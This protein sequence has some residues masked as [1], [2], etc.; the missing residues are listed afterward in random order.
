MPYTGYYQKGFIGSRCLFHKAINSA[1]IVDPSKVSFYFPT[2]AAVS[3]FS[4]FL[5]G[6]TLMVV[7]SPVYAGNNMTFP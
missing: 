6:N 7:N 3:F 1:I 2:L 5:L 4:K